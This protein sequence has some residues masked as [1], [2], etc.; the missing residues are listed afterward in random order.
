MKLQC[1]AICVATLFLVSFESPV[2]RA[3]GFTNTLGM[4]LVLIPAG[5]FQMGTA[6]D[7]KDTLKD[8]PYAPRNWVD[9]ETPRHRVRITRAF[10]MATHET[11][12]KDFLRFYHGANYKLEAELDGRAN[13]G[14][15]AAGHEI[16]SAKFRPWQP[17]WEQDE[18]HPVN[19]VSWNDAVAFCRWLSEQEGR[20]YRLPTEAEWEYACRAG[21]TT[22][23]SCGDDPEGLVEIANVADQTAKGKWPD[24][25]VEV[26]KDGRRTHTTI[27]FPYLKG[28]DGYVVT[29]P[30]GKFRPNAF[31][32]H[33]MH[34]NL[35]EWC[36]DVYEENYYGRSPV[37]DPA[38]P[39]DGATR[40]MRGGGF[41]DTTI[42]YRSAAR[43]DHR[44]SFRCPRT[45]FRVVCELESDTAVT[46]QPIT[47]AA[48][49]NV[50]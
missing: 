11:R 44:P 29:A 47:P 15:D 43:L 39:T 13:F 4:P 32:L 24:A 20:K 31:G 36:Q 46:T 30:V 12:L 26:L 45:G 48:S 38:G 40:V 17:G 3:D 7:P 23:Y 18:E 6:E 35:W 25:F 49:G 42:Y 14:L 8:F 50:E 22:R 5:E 33:D 41:D 34:G 37:N 10:Y 2:A 21:T 9:G 1:L 27:P 16:K 28:D 19:Y